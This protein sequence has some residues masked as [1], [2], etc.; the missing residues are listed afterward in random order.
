LTAALPDGWQFASDEAL[1]AVTGIARDTIEQETDLEAGSTVTLMLCS[2][3]TF[4]PASRVSN[5]NI[6]IGFTNS[7]STINM[8]TDDALYNAFIDQYVTV[9]NDLYGGADSQL[10]GERNVQI[11]GKT[12]TAVYAEVSS[13]DF[14]MYQDQY[15]T[16][17]SGGVLITTLTYF[18]RAEKDK[19]LGFM[20]NLSYE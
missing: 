5:P 8:L 18:D 20:Q 13:S 2:Q 12:Y 4:D 3:D 1:E 19:L 17:I 9:Y 6:N 10:T 14:T 11:N 15:Y 7:L 16:N